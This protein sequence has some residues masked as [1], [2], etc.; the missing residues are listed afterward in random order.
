MLP[1]PYR[2]LRSGIAGSG[3]ARGGAPASTAMGVYLDGLLAVLGE[4]RL[5]ETRLAA[6]EVEQLVAGGG[7]D[8]WRDRPADSKPQDVVV[9]SHVADAREGLERGG[10]DGAGEAQLD[11]VVGEIPQGIDRVDLHQPSLADDRDPV[12]GLLDLAQDVAGEEGRPTLGDQLAEGP[13]EALLDERVEA[14]RRLVEEE[15]LGAMLEGNDEADLL[16]VP[17]R[18]LFEPARRV[19]V[20]ALDQRCLVRAIHATAKVGE[21][22]E[23]LGAGEAVVERELARQ[24]ADPAVDRHRVGGRVDAEDAGDARCGPDEV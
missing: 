8:D 3:A 5:L 22:L 23:R 10:R 20:E 13:E 14:G 24:V 12:T 15:E 2:R 18:V 11:L 17:L 6:H 9:D 16:L 1:K 4:E 19:E 7:L 21:V